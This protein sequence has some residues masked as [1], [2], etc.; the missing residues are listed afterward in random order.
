MKKALAILFYCVIASMIGSTTVKAQS[1]PINENDKFKITHTSAPAGA[2]LEFEV[3][4]KQDIEGLLIGFVYDHRKFSDGT[5]IGHSTFNYSE[6][7]KYADWTCEDSQVLPDS[8]IVRWDPV[9]AGTTFKY[10]MRT[11]ANIRYNA[12]NIRND[13]RCAL[14]EV[15]DRA[16]WRNPDEFA[17]ALGTIYRSDIDYV[18]PIENPDDCWLSQA[19][20]YPDPPV[21]INPV[22]P[23]K[24]VP[25]TCTNGLFPLREVDIFNRYQDDTGRTIKY[26]T[27]YIDEEID[28]PFKLPVVDVENNSNFTY[29]TKNIDN[30][31][32]LQSPI[33]KG[34]RIRT[35]DGA[36]SLIGTPVK[37]EGVSYPDTSRVGWVASGCGGSFRFDIIVKEYPVDGSVIFITSDENE[38]PQEYKLSQNYPNPFNPAT[39]IEYNL[40]R[41]QSVKLIVYDMLGQEI[42]VL[43]NGI[44]SQ[45]NHR[46]IFDASTLPSGQYLYRLETE[47]GIETKIMSLLK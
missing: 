1:T 15:A 13:V 31:G 10:T 2:D 27:F 41:T 47:S 3:E 23:T 35:I 45:G 11:C 42:Q 14:V 28:P 43:V 26:K 37:E 7:N 19:P 40:D 8:N 17:F 30:P 21:I 33:P 18:E 20:E 4:I 44:L 38:T 9:S 36:K 6:S 5:R 24:P 34:M 22:N 29:S 32:S 12:A 46:A 25:G 16:D 39:T